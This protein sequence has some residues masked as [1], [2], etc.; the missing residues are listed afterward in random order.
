M[1]VKEI[2]KINTEHTVSLL[3]K[4]LEIQLAEL[5]EDWH[6]WSLEKYSLKTNL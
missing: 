2:L 4:E 3:K 5:E 1:S 6:R